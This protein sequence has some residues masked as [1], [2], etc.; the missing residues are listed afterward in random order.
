MSYRRLWPHHAEEGDAG[1]RYY[2]E[3]HSIRGHLS[4]NDGSS[5]IH[6]LRSDQT[7]LACADVSII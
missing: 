1:Y 2:S 3:N 5:I 6:I 7:S 4:S